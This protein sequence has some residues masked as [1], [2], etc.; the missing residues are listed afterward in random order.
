MSA[1]GDFRVTEDCKD[2]RK[3]GEIMIRRPLF[4]VAM[5][6]ITNNVMAQT[7][8]ICDAV[9]SPTVFNIG[10]TAN[11]E[12]FASKFRDKFCNEKWSSHNDIQ[13]RANSF[14]LNYADAESTLGL[15]NSDYSNSSILDQKYDSFCRKT[16]Q[17]IAYSSSFFNRYRSS[18]FAVAQW[19]K[20]IEN[21]AE[22][23]FALVVPDQGLTG[24]VIRLTRKATGDV[25]TLVVNSVQ[26]GGSYDVSCYYGSQ[27]VNSSTIFPERQREVSLTCL[28]RPDIAATFTINTNWGT[29][30]P[31]YIP[32]YSKT[33]STLQ[34]DIGAERSRSETALNNEVAALKAQFNTLSHNLMNGD[35]TTPKYD[36]PLD[37]PPFNGVAGVGNAQPPHEFMTCASGYY[38]VGL[39]VDRTDGG[40]NDARI[41]CQRVNAALK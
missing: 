17:D 28:K 26:P 10:E 15:S 6:I 20:C 22:G 9:L 12:I 19:G 23:H 8:N 34:S 14:G 27:P 30:D 39:Y 29:F 16:V 24:A 4:A 35:T 3:Q 21:T 7:G 38:V 32:G 11:A 2:E 18:D 13:N 36:P 31:V 37:K 41:V 40:F 5:I 1:R 33:I 25:P